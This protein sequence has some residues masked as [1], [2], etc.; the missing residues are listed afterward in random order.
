[1]GKPGATNA[2]LFAAQMLAVQDEDLRARLAA[3]R[4][5][6]AAAVLAHPDPR[7]ALP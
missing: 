3:R 4:D 5:A 2:G 7:E 6:A 1:M